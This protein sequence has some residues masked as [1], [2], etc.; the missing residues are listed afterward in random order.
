VHQLRPHLVVQL[1][2]R[3][4]QQ[5]LPLLLVLELPDDLRPRRVGL[6]QPA[7]PL[8]EAAPDGLDLGGQRLGL[9]RLGRLGRRRRDRRAAA[10]ARRAPR[11]VAGG[12]HGAHRE[13]RRL[14]LGRLLA[15]AARAALGQ[16]RLRVG[17]HADHAQLRLVLVAAVLIV[18]VWRKGG[19]GLRGAA[20][21]DA[22]GA[23]RRG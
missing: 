3:A 19:G 22:R 23:A 6:L 4:A 15:R 18:P 10:A 8:G 20:R 14:A 12:I 16:R 21:K 11:L 7:A 2:Q 17:A 13:A 9:V 5:V 1:R